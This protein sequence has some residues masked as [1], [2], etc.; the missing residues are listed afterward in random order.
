MSE[1]VAVLTFCAIL[2]EVTRRA[3][4]ARRAGGVRRGAGRGGGGGR[5]RRAAGRLQRGHLCRGG[6]RFGCRGRA[7][8]ARGLRH[9][10][11]GPS[12]YSPCDYGRDQGCGHAAC[13]RASRRPRAAWWPS[14]ML[15][16]RTGR[17]SAAPAAQEDDAAF[18]NRLVPAAERPEDEDAAALG[19]RAARLRAADEVRQG[20]RRLFGRVMQCGWPCCAGS[21]VQMLAGDVLQPGASWACAWLKGFSDQPGLNQ[22][23]WASITLLSLPGGRANPVCDALRCK[24]CLLKQP[25]THAL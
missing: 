2:D 15:G 9:Y 18:W 19:V 12:C 21:A 8:P 10:F 24:R 6:A 22:P 11:W 5:G 16:P 3:E 14:A 20:G 1:Q 17:P 23:D 13:G 25:R 4:S 7:V